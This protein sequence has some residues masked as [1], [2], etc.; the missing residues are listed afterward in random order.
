[1]VQFPTLW[2]VL[3]PENRPPVWCQDACWLRY[4]KVGLEI[5]EP[6]QKEFAAALSRCLLRG[7]DNFLIPQ[8]PEN[9]GH[10]YPES[11]NESERT[12]VLEYLKTLSA[13]H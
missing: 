12:A 9:G 8:N 13:G 1:M 10:T 6:S 11:L 2:H 4:K 3:H 5:E 7:D